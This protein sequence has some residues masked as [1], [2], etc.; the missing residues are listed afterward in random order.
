M[1]GLL[2]PV[3]GN[4]NE[5]SLPTLSGRKAFTMRCIVARESVSAYCQGAKR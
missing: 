3:S 4:Q 1:L 5:E 2:V